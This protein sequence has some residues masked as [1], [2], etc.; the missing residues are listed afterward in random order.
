MAIPRAAKS[1]SPLTTGPASPRRN[2]SRCW[3]ATAYPATFFHCGHHLRRLPE[4]AR[5]VADAG[6]ELGNHTETHPAFYFRSRHFMHCE[7]LAAQQSFADVLGRQP[8]LFRPPYGVRW[9]GLGGVQQELGLT[10]ILWTVLGC[11]WKLPAP[12]I[13]ARVTSRTTNGAIICL[14]DGRGL[15]PRPDISAT[16]AAADVI[17]SKLGDCGFH[18]ATVSDLLCLS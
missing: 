12:A 4:I 16:L 10:S 5:A 1:R 18:F 13:A 3:R 2:C 7:L 8:T 9:P 11:D 14:H 6:H 17:I 15:T